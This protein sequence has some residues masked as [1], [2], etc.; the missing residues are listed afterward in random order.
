M[1]DLNVYVYV[2]DD[3]ITLHHHVTI[4]HN[5]CIYVYHHLCPPPPVPTTR[6]QIVQF[7]LQN[8]Q[9]TAAFHN[10]VPMNVDPYTGSGAY[11]PGTAGPVPGSRGPAGGV[12]NGYAVTGGGA[13]PYTGGQ[14]GGGGGGSS[15]V[16]CRCV[17]LFVCV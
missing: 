17:C 8:T 5:T 13:D 4:S 6:E 11:V 7:I 12:G 16:P 15:H 1:M 9:D 10:P 2:Y 14:S 3:T